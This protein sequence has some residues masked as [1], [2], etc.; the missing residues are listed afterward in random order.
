M[1]AQAREQLLEGALRLSRSGLNSGTA[2]NLSLRLEGGL[3][4]TPSSVPPEQMGPA[5][6]V[7]IDW[8]GQP[9]S[10]SGAA[11]GRAPSLSLIH[12]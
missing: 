3:L 12:I 9:L 5:D 6:L 2:G 4:I 7:A 8:Q 1:E 10:G 11:S